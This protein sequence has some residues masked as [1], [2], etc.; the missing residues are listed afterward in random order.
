MNVRERKKERR[1]RESERRIAK[2]EIQKTERGKEEREKQ[3][4]RQRETE[5]TKAK[6]LHNSLCCGCLVPRAAYNYICK[7]RII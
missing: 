1:E 6:A 7:S 2:K 5:S 4:D 3:T